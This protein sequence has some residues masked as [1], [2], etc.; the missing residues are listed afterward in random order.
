VSFFRREDKSA[1]SRS[2]D[3]KRSSSG[4]RDILKH[5]KENESLRVL[6]FGATSSHNINYLTGMGHSVYMANL[7]ADAARPEWQKVLE[8]GEAPRFDVQG[9]VEQNLNFSGRDFDVVLVWDTAD[10]LPPEVVPALFQKLHDVLRSDGRLL[11][12][13]HGAKPDVSLPFPRYQL[14][15]TDEV[16][17]LAS[18]EF[19][20]L[21]TYQT[22]QIEKFLAG[23]ASFRFFLGKDN[24]REVIA[25]R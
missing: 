7:V 17:L 1:A 18:G 8:E 3:R 15:E 19:P 12:F 2:A 9:F 10:Y 25:I 6:D 5:L 21:Q 4:W 24:V 13:F 22:R 23:Y 16:L 11:A 20:V 14:T